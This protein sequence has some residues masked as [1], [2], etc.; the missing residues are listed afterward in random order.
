MQI[1]PK[2]EA[3]RNAEIAG[4]LDAAA[5]VIDSDHG[6]RDQFVIGLA[7]VRPI[8][9]REND[10]SA[11]LDQPSRKHRP[12]GRR[13]RDDHV[14]VSHRFARIGDRLDMPSGKLR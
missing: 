7:S 1:L 11:G 12:V 4:A 10:K 6:A 9:T 8:R 5:A 2:E 14:G 13:D 3:Q